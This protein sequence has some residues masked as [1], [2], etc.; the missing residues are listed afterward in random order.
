MSKQRLVKSTSRSSPL[1]KRNMRPK[2]S[3]T[4]N[5]LRMKLSKNSSATSSGS[6][7]QSLLTWSV[8]KG[9][10]N[11]F[12][13]KRSGKKPVVVTLKRKSAKKSRESN[14]SKN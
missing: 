10:K 6:P 14:E 11:I 1:S 7:Q 12:P 4:E 8:K 2:S 5:L 13:S 9:A 3:T